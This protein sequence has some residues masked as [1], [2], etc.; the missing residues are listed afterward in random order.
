MINTAIRSG[1]LLVATLAA[2]AC[3]SRVASESGGSDSH[4]MQGGVSPAE[5]HD[6]QS[7]P[8]VAFNHLYV[9]VPAEVIDQFSR[10]E[11]LR[12]RL[13]ASDQG[14]P[15]FEPVE[16][17][18]QS[19]YLRGKHTYLEIFGPSNRFEE[20]VGKLGLAFS[21]EVAGEIDQVEDRLREAGGRQ[22]RD[23]AE[24]PRVGWQRHLSRWDFDRESPVNWYHVVHRT[25]TAEDLCVW[26][27]SEFHPDFLPALYPDRPTSEAGIKRSH[28]LAGRHDERRWLRDIVALVLVLTPDVANDLA[29]DL[30][31][32]GCTIEERNDGGRSLSL[33]PELQIVLYAG[34]ADDSLG[35][36]SIGI[37]T[38]PQTDGAL[39]QEFPGGVTLRLDGGELG[40]IDFAT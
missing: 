8:K 37:S 20:P 2:V 39:R 25:F 31:A 36:R 22:Y 26:W 1:P 24:R 17:A 32:V 5:R 18:S 7:G 13:A 19:I 6:G 33:G 12:D 40:W 14:L 23:N 16:P 29:E 9:V 10:S 3:S 4:G 28:F 35:L 34:G 38:Y 30:S 21:T 15:K 11:V 27:F